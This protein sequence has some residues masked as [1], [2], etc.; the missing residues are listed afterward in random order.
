[1]N[2]SIKEHIKY[3]VDLKGVSILNKETNDTR[4]I[5]Y[6]EASIWLLFCEDHGREKSVKMLSAILNKTEIDTV[7]FIE[8]YLII[9][10]NEGLIYQHG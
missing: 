9:L 8:D 5:G 1:M 3:A 6:P 4:F 10:G 7:D 2:F